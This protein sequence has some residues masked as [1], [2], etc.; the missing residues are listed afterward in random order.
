M[1]HI[2]AT[3]LNNIKVGDDCVIGLGAVVIKDV[4]D[5]HTAVGVPAVNKERV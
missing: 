2:S 1:I 3:I 4:P 5:N